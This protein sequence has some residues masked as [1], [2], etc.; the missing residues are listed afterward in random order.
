MNLRKMLICLKVTNSPSGFV[1]GY[2]HIN[3]LP[4]N[5]IKTVYY[6]ME[7]NIRWTERT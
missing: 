3:R 5:R 2:M 1:D 6:D 4:H 7:K